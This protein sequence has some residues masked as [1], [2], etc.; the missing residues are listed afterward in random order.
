[1]FKQL[2]YFS[3][4]LPILGFSQHQLKGVFSPANEFKATMLYHLS[5]G[6]ATYMSYG[7]VNP[8]GEMKI[9]LDASAP[10]GIYKLVYALP[11]ADHNFEFIY[12]A[13]EDVVFNFNPDSGVTFI[14]SKEN[15]LFHSYTQAINN[16]QK[17]LLQMYA[18]P[19]MKSRV[20]KRRS[21]KVDSI[22][23]RYTLLSKGTI[24]ARFINASQPYIAAKVESADLFTKNV[25]T[26][27]FDAIDFKDQLLQSSNFL[28][29][30][31]IDYILRMH[32]SATPLLQD[33]KANID[34]VS[35]QFSS[36]EPSFQLTSL[37]ALNDLLIESQQESLALY[38]TKTFLLPIAIQLKDTE[39]ITNS[40]DFMRIAIGVKA[41]NFQVNNQKS[42]YDLD[43]ATNYLLIFW[44][45][46][47]G[48]CLK[49]LPEVYSYLAS[50]P[51]KDFKV[52]AIG[53]ETTP[54]KWQET[55]KLWPQ[56]THVLAKGKWDS[57]LSKLY[58]VEATPSYY[59][60]DAS[61]TITSKPYL[62][63]DLMDVLDQK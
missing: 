41:P 62:L 22:Q 35:K 18:K 23:K 49:E 53:L 39:Q 43:D 40:E 52:V 25:K 38:L 36:T 50:R 4:I 16:A 13:N 11:Q 33:Y 58:A 60:L 61:K 1:M 27:Y 55:I 57:K 37:V 14:N 15:Q 7:T 63:K 9:E 2:F 19:S 31:S 34:E 21:Q 5:E 12:D 10:S 30:K 6:N 3:V 45:S 51:E 24:A 56:F 59:L 26:H 47:C 20:Y 32:T 29:D 28:I 42:L 54:A 46:D 8:Q 17:E 44:S 48:H